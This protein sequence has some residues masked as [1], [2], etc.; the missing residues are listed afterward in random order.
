MKMKRFRQRLQNQKSFVEYFLQTKLF[1]PTKTLPC[2]IIWDS[3]HEFFF[4]ILLSRAPYNLLSLLF[5]YCIAFHLILVLSSPS[6][7]IIS[8]V[9][10]CFLLRLLVSVMYQPPKSIFSFLIFNCCYLK[11]HDVFISDTISPSFTTRRP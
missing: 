1:S 2:T 9:I 3:L 11:L 8:D 7:F 10:I 4:V 5:I 6:I